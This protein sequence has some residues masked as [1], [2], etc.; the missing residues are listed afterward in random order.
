MKKHTILQHD[1]LAYGIH[2]FHINFNTREI[3][4]TPNLDASNDEA[5]INHYVAANLIKNIRFFDYL[6]NKPI[7]IHMCTCGGQQEY[8][9]AVYD[10]IK[11]SRSYIYIIAYAYAR[12]MSSII[13]QAADCRIL[14]PHTY[15][16][17]HYGTDGWDGTSPGLISH[18]KQ[19][20]KSQI[21]M[22]ELYSER[23][24]NGSYFTNRHM[25]IKKVKE[26][27]NKKMLD[28]QEWYLSPEKAI[29]YGF[30]DYILGK[31]KCPTIKQILI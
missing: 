30:A 13:L 12:S 29:K 20:K 23:C 17:I 11:T 4:L 22:L 10:S 18:A 31:G 19:A 5:E 14:T 26:F 8:G 28:K 24:Q 7:L 16:M 25:N 1:E 3:F 9:L 6:N 15:C 27:L 21:Q 2:N